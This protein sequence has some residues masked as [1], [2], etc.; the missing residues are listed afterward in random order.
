[1]DSEFAN[2]KIFVCKKYRH[3]LKN[4]KLLTYGTYAIYT[5]T[6]THTACSQINLNSYLAWSYHLIQ[7]YLTQHSLQVQC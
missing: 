2:I 4:V 7:L 6:H 1:M 3:H 5:H